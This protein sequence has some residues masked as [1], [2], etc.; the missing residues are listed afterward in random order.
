MITAD[1]FISPTDLATTGD[2]VSRVITDA[3]TTPARRVL[4]FGRYAQWNG[5]FGGGVASLSGKI[6]R[7]RSQLLDPNE[8]I[9]ALADRSVLVAS[10]IFDASRD[11]FNDRSTKHRD[12]HRCLGQAHLKGLLAVE[13][14]RNPLWAEPDQVNAFLATPSWL[15]N[16]CDS[17][18][19]GYGSQSGDRPAAVFQAMGYH[20][21][22]ELLADQEFST[23][24]QA[25][26]T[27][28]PDLVSAM[29]TLEVAIGPQKHK[30]YSWLS[31]HSGYGGGVEADHF[32]WATRGV[33]LAL[34]L[35]AP[36]ER[37]ERMN[38]LRRGFALFVDQ[39]NTFFTQMS[40][41]L[42]ALPNA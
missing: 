9:V 23:I 41:E 39:H 42:A 28:C 24:D 25:L 14:V 26:R 8:P 10:Y 32:E 6:V 15:D 31:I 37:A 38:D 29:E 34:D 16:L 36:S 22:S 17:V 1:D 27:T 33:R 20:V 3:V 13:A 11:E 5:L 21:G 40:A 12:T 4:F 7:L 30:A 35:T 19:V 2:R 18:G